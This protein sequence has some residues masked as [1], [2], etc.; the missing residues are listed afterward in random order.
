M[1]LLKIFYFLKGYVIIE[2]FDKKIYEFINL[3]TDNGITVRNVD[4]NTLSLTKAD[5]K[6]VSELANRF[7]YEF[8][9]VNE[10]GLVSTLSKRSCWFFITA[11]L[12]FALFMYMSSGY[13]WTVEIEG[14]SEEVAKK[15]MEAA[16][17][18]G[19][20]RGVR[21]KNLPTHNEMKDA[22]LYSTDELYWAWV[23]LDGTCARISVREETEKPKIPEI[24]KS[25]N[26]V[27]SRDGYIT[28]I[29]AEN[30]RKLY[31][32]GT[33]VKEGDILI[34]GV[35][36]ESEKNPAYTVAAEGEVIAQTVYT[37]SCK[38]PLY[39][40][41]TKDT[42]Y[43]RTVYSLRLFELEIPLYSK[44]SPDMAEYR[45]TVNTPPVGICT[46][47][48][49]ETETVR[50]EIPIDVAV[51]EAKEALYEK[52]ASTL[53]KGAHKTDEK[54]TYRRISE[55]M[56]EV[57]LVMNFNENIGIKKETEE[58]QMEE[59]TDDKTD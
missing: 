12:I 30:G 39:K 21:K 22:I 55:D 7:G 48:Y 29:S 11:F 24:G 53:S 45:I 51:W 2:L 44:K 34:S 59:N 28:Y 10:Y 13:V 8:K 27:A 40:S 5:F 50:E 41:Y 20:R 37:K 56:L 32:P 38:Y 17:G 58:W 19:L 54:V 3:L 26:I 49:T 15:V 33:W 42:G 47:K 1:F 23:Y 35:M 18:I 25:C 36:R 46:K 16:D 6:Y 9:A 4:G 43:E 57:T 31:T 14:C 52:I